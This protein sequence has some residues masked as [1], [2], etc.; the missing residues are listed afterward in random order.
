MMNICDYRFSR[1]VTKMQQNDNI[2]WKVYDDIQTELAE[3]TQALKKMKQRVK[4]RKNI[5]GNRM[6]FMIQNLTQGLNAEINDIQS[7]FEKDRQDYL[8]SIRFFG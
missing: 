6:I 2:C 4:V 1:L 3:K 5:P 8:D 7:E